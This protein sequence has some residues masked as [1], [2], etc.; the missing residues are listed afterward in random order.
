MAKKN[1]LLDPEYIMVNFSVY[2]DLN[3]D[4]ALPIIMTNKDNGLRIGRFESIAAIEKWVKQGHGAFTLDEGNPEGDESG[5]GCFYQWNPRAAQ[6]QRENRL[7]VIHGCAGLINSRP[8]D[9]F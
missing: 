1:Y 8:A 3:P 9:Y 4:G 5:S 2:T 6:K 7:P